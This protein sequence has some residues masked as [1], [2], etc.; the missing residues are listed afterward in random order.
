MKK[1]RSGSESDASDA[2][3]PPLRLVDP[4]PPTPPTPPTVEAIDVVVDVLGDADTA[5]HGFALITESDPGIDDS[6]ESPAADWV[7]PVDGAC[8]I[9]HPIKANAQS[10]IFHVPGGRSYDRTIA[11]RCY[12]SGDAAVADGYR[13]AK[14]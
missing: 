11:E 7:E 4:I 14:V 5:P 9:G 13:Q 1:R 8:P 6:I 12:S 10:K 3:W 2:A